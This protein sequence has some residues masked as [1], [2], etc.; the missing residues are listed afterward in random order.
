MEFLHLLLEKYGV[1]G[2]VLAGV[3]TVL[4]FAQLI[5][6]FR[7]GRIATYTNNRRKL[8]REEEPPVSLIVPMFTE[9]Y[10]FIE[11]RLPLMLRQ[12]Y[13]N[14]EVVV[15]YVGQ[16]SDFHE[17]LTLLRQHF[18]HLVI[19]RIHHDPRYPIS[20]KMALNIGIKSAH[21]ECMLFTSTDVV[22][23]GTR[24][25]ALMAKGF[26]RGDIVLGY[27]GLERKGGLLNRLFR[28][29]RMLRSATWL[30]RAVKGKPYRGILHSYGFTKSVYISPISKGFN[31]LGMNIGEDD[32]F[33]QA[34][35]NKENTSVI[36]AP[37]A[38]VTQRVWGGLRWWISQLTYYGA[39][40]PFYPLGVRLSYL[41]ELLS[42]VLFFAAA[43]I[44]L[45]GMPNDFRIA[46]GALVAL[47]FLVVLWQVHRI[48]R[49]LG[50]RR[51]LVAFP[52]Y[53]LLSPCW[54]LFLGLKLLRKDRRVWR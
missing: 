39:T 54:S 38:T 3:L 21:H 5:C 8:I 14:F 37:A 23:R 12:E 32:L 43:V 31:H 17:E 49:R 42:R 18:P 11:E 36:L 53:D 16:N 9:D 22:P 41:W 33:I 25:L 13:A 44:A 30:A 1:E 2:L 26:S 48:A 24:W 7:Y 15:I 19:S 29:G 34:V 47:R 35:A 52:I 46:V 6:Y 28:L 4:L 51:L 50:E 27:C 10:G 45:I 20:R 40:I